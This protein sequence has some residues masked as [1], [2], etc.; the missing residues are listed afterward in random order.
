MSDKNGYK[1][2]YAQLKR[3]VQNNLSITKD[4]TF[5]F[6]I[7]NQFRQKDASTFSTIEM[8]ILISLSIELSIPIFLFGKFGKSCFFQITV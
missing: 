8:T 3:K 1:I 2:P 5:P 4:C 6:N 7:K